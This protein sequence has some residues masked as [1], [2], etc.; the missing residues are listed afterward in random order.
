MFNTAKALALLTFKRRRSI[1]E[2]SSNK[3]KQNKETNLMQDKIKNTTKKVAGNTRVQQC[4]LFCKALG[5]TL[6]ILG[7]AAL[8]AYLLVKYNDRI[9]NGLGVAFGLA[10]LLV[11]VNST[12]LAEAKKAARK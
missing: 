11:L 2:E 6:L 3:H 12:Y 4:T 10:S 9:I 7:S 5:R 8:S 1:L